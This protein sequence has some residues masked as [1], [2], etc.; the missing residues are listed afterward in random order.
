MIIFTETDRFL[1]VPTHS[2]SRETKP[3]VIDR[4]TAAISVEGAVLLLL[5]YDY[6]LCK[7]AKTFSSFAVSEISNF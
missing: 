6:V 4:R 3:L 2:T 7:Q 5:N 1:I